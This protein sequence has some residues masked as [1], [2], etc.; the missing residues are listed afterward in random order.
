MLV[1][2]STD[3]EHLIPPVGFARLFM[4]QKE[5][6]E[7]LTLEQ[8]PDDDCDFQEIVE[9]SYIWMLFVSATVPRK[10]PHTGKTC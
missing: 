9:F 8:I 2:N 3:A 7:K 10:I 4:M 1:D 6:I 5:P